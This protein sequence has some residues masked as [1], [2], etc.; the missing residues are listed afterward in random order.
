VSRYVHDGLT[1]LLQQVNGSFAPEGS[2]PSTGDQPRYLATADFNGDA[3][4]DL[5]VSNVAG[6]SVTVLLRKASGPGFD[7]EG[8]AIPVGDAPVAIAASDLT[9][10]GR[11]DLA[12]ANSGTDNV[13][14]LVRQPGGGFAPLAGSPFTA[15]DSP[16]G[17]VAADFNGDG[18]RDLATA[19]NAAGNVSVLLR[20]P[21]GG[22]TP[23]PGSPYPAALGPNQVAADDFNGDAKADL[24]ISNDSSNNLTVLLNTT[25]DPVPE[26]PPSAPQPA[27]PATPTPATTT[28]TT[29][30]V[31]SINARLVLAWTITRAH[32]RLTSAVLRD[33]PAGGAT[34]KVA[35][36]ACKLSQTIAA[37]RPTLTLTKL[38]DR[39]L[40]RGASFTVTV[41]KPGHR[42][43]VFTRTVKRYGRSK[44]ALR[45]AVKAPFREARTVSAPPA[46]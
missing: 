43:L 40:K 25:P 39:R 10:D 27:Q 6:D 32:V 1:I 44:A 33:L 34:V 23:Q 28:T 36:R 46:G 30:T 15:G 41:S 11:P 24:A 16:Y 38:R 8:P 35:C 37:K 5:A 31:P 7:P 14:V 22:F 45:R 13:S 12:V 19:N 42:G 26:P 20:Q 18:W 4:P 29:T 17:V 2:P 9:G 21:G 3:R